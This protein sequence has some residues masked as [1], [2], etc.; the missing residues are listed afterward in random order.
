MPYSIGSAHFA[1]KDGITKRCREIVEQTP[2]GTTVAQE[3]FVFLIA[4]FQHHDEWHDKSYP[5]VTSISTQTTEHGTRGFILNRTDGSPIDISSPHAIK[6][7]PTAHT[8]NLTP[9]KLLDYKAAART[10]VQNQVRDFRDLALSAATSCPINNLPLA[11]GNCDVHYPP[12][13][14]FEGLLLRFTKAGGI[15]PLSVVVDSCGTVAK[16]HDAGLTSAW[17]AYHRQ[18]A[19]LQLVSREGRQSRPKFPTDWSGVL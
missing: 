5:D 9:Q 1:T 6:R 11:S 14:T 15:T 3:D 8:A 2:D 17:A 12:P 10:A 13:D 7:I 18:H 19:K 16:F 4:L